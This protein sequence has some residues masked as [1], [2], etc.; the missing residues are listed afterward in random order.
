MEAE[1]TT[2]VSSVARKLATSVKTTRGVANAME[3]DGILAAA[4]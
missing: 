3:V 1:A 4:D 2:P